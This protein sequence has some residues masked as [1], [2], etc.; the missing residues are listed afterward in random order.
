[1]GPI[2]RLLCALL[3]GF[4]TGTAWA[5]FDPTAPPKIRSARVPTQSSLAWVRVNGKNS[6]AWYNGMIVK[7]GDQVEGGRVVAIREDHIVIAGRGGH[8][9]ISLL[10][11]QVQHNPVALSRSPRRK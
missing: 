8:R 7:L 4:A 3:A 10:D 2:L 11:P 6:I 1:M 9:T 5:D